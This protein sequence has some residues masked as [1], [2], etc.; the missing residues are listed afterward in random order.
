[1]G[2]RDGCVEDQAGGDLL[3]DLGHDRDLDDVHG[4]ADDDH[5]A[6]DGDGC[7]D[8]PAGG[9]LEQDHC[10]YCF[11]FIMMMVMVAMMITVIVVIHLQFIGARDSQV[12]FWI[13]ICSKSYR[14]SI[15]LI[16]KCGFTN[17]NTALPQAPLLALDVTRQFGV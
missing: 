12:L 2:C 15:L 10:Y 17:T 3:D 6:G 4:Y 7:V 1:M 16:V 5:D 11:L 9:D 14:L 8:D 13:H